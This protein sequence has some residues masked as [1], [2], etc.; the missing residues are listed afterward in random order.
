MSAPR[1]RLMPVVM[2]AAGALLALKLVGL[3]TDS[4]VVFVPSAHA[5][6]KPEPA[7][8]SKPAAGG[9]KPAAADPKPADPKPADPNAA[10]GAAPGGSAPALADDS[11][12]SERALI[13]ALKKRREALEQRS[14]DLDMRE[15]L[16]KAAEKRIEDRLDELKRVEQTVSDVD[17][18]RSD[19]EKAR[20]KSIVTMYEGMKPKE[21][22]RIFEK[23]EPPVLLQVASLMNPRKLADVLGLMSPEA[24]QKLTVALAQR[25]VGITASA[26]LAASELPKI[27]SRPSQ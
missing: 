13:E 20:F 18:K 5:E 19:D 23:L 24:A 1:M 7:P 2:T 11:S 22:A 27:E 8:E 16:L 21:S 3:A 25:D 6:A 14:T 26:A 4:S 12:Q 15:A 17:Q 9:S 10:A